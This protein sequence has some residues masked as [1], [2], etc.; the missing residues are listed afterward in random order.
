MATTHFETNTARDR[1]IRGQ[2][3]AFFAGIGMGFNAYLERRGRFDEI[4]RLNAKTD[5]ELAAMGI[6]RD[7]IVHY[8]FRDK[9]GF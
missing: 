4:E 9:M 8:V 7:R 5:A 2:I 3:D 6:S 1:S